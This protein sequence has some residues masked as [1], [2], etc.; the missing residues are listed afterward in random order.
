MRPVDELSQLF[1]AL[2]DPTRRAVL[3]RL[4]E[5]DLTVGEIAEP[6][7]MTMGAVS[8]HLAILENAGL[9]QTERRGQFRHK[10]LC[11]DRLQLAET[12][13]SWF[14]RFHTDTFDRLETYLAEIGA[15]TKKDTPHE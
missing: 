4:A 7:E 10:K 11:S 3:A 9:I 5:R 15:E 8:K 12:W 14:R 6:I 13:L 1:I 2:G